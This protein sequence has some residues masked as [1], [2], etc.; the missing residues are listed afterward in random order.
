[1]IC[2]IFY[3]GSENYISLCVN[4]LKCRNGINRIS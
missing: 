2:E 3:K 4:K 1:M